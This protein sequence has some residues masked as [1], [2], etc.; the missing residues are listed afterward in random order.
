MKKPYLA[1]ILLFA[2][3]LAVSCV[4]SSSANGIP[5]SSLS[6]PALNA[7]PEPE[8]LSPGEEY[9]TLVESYIDNAVFEQ[10]AED[11]TKQLSD[12]LLGHYDIIGRTAGEGMD[13]YL[14]VRR[15]DAPVYNDFD[16][17]D[18]SYFSGPD[19]KNEVLKIGYNDKSMNPT[20]LYEMEGYRLLE[21]PFGNGSLDC[22]CFGKNENFGET[23][24]PAFRLAFTQSGRE[25][26]DFI[27]SKPGLSLSSGDDPCIEFYYQDDDTLKF[28]SSP[29]SCFIDI[30]SDELEQIRGL[31]SASNIIDSVKTRQ[32][33]WKYL[34]LKDSSIYTTGAIL[35][36][37]GKKYEFPGNKN[38]IGH[39]MATGADRGFISIE[40][41]E[42]VYNFVMDKIRSVAEMDYGNFDAEWFKVP[43][44]S[45]S[46]D[47]PERAEQADGSYLSDMRSQTIND[48]EKLDALSKLMDQAINGE[49]IYGFSACPYIAEIE[50]TRRDG[51]TLR[52]FIAADSCDSMTYEGRIGFEYG[53]QLAMAEIFDEA[54]ADRLTE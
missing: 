16:S 3:P 5:E 14:A 20:V 42:A 34:H 19:T 37:D 9:I 36:I 21:M 11:G 32:D 39:M 30:N 12:M 43:L 15:E 17:I 26:L 51:E 1:L 24:D 44:K 47:F 40:Y 45:A 46:M 22:F 53:S 23:S 7:I 8:Q 18:T 52:V 41:N 49:E 38:T 4:K 54:M 25:E 10:M 13:Y 31:L 29:Y 27:K 2:A 28:C 50:F 33:A 35:H 6:S 48:A